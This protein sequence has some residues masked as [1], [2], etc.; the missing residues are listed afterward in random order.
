MP[1]SDTTPAAGKRQLEIEL[2]M[3]GEERLLRRLE[4][5]ALGRELAKARIR[6][7]HP[8]WPSDVQEQWSVTKQLAE[9]AF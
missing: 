9:I 4:M 1:L 7:D 6:N 3:T 8:D 2:A 5:S